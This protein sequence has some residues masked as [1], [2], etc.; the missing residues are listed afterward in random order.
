MGFFDG[1]GRLIRGEPIF[2]DHPKKDDQ[3]SDDPWRQDD[4][5]AGEQV[6]PQGSQLVD[7]KGRKIIPA[8]HIER[9]KSY[10]NG[11]QMTVTAWAT[12]T[13]DVE[14]KLDKIEILGMR[15]ELDRF[16]SPG[17][18]HEITIYKGPAPINDHY[19]EAVLH[20][21]IVKN[22]DYFAAEFMIEYNRES[23][24]IYIVEDLHSESVIRDV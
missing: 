14:I 10:V 11:P 18:G 15:Y 9:C 7:E 8:I 24:G 17:K 20:Y 13:G 2:V 23:S 19:H 6:E 16:L 1:L 21:K 4:A 3:D 12:N 22:G 5:P